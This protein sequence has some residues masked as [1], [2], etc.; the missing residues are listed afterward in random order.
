MS[1]GGGGAFALVQARDGN[2]YGTTGYGGASG[3]GT[4]FKMTSTGVL[5]TLFSFNGTDG[6]GPEAL[7]QARNGVFYGAAGT[8]GSGSN[9]SPANC[10]T[11][12]SL[13]V[14]MGGTT[15][16]TAIL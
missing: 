6:S 15:P 2:V 14:P 16:S 11:I 4:L 9:C 3:N 7:L 10:G 1:D 12:F 5:I 13:T 8:G